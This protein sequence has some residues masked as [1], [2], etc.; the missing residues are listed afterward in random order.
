[1]GYIIFSNDFDDDENAAEDVDN[2][3]TGLHISLL[4][5]NIHLSHV[6]PRS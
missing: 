4:F 2:D 6:P 1:M 3:R 5:V